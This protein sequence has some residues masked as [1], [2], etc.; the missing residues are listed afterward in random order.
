MFAAYE[1]STR[2]ARYCLK[3]N[4][5][6]TFVRFGIFIFLSG[7]DR[8]T[9]YQYFVICG[10]VILIFSKWM[11]IWKKYIVMQLGNLMFWIVPLN[12]WSTKR[13]VL[14]Y[15]SFSL[16]VSVTCSD[17]C[18]ILPQMETRGSSLLPQY[19]GKYNLEFKIFPTTHMIHVIKLNLTL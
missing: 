16:Q 4:I 10:D 7:K 13:T 11:T 15:V 2:L 12:W 1:A 5:A 18:E 19:P 6:K 14:Q 17:K 9:A 8:C 3:M